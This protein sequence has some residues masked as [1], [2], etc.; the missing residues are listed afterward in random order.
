MIEVNFLGAFNTCKAVLTELQKSNH[1]DIILLGDRADRYA[2]EVGIGYC[3]TKFEIQ[4]FSEALYLDVISDDIFV[5]L[6]APGTVDTEFEKIKGQGWQ[7][8]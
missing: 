5:S 3:A 6:I 7:Q 1:A 4:G 8:C 2:F